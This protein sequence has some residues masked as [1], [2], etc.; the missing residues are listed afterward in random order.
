PDQD[1]GTRA[2]S[3]I[4]TAP[5]MPAAA[6]DGIGP[7]PPPATGLPADADADGT[8]TI[9]ATT[10]ASNTFLIDVRIIPPDL[11]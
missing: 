8:A 4:V 6:P 2:G 3:T 11:S 10:A 9:P 7:L 5:T 1:S